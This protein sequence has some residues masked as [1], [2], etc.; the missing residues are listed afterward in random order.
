MNTIPDN[1]A[2]RPA[3]PSAALTLQGPVAQPVAPRVRNSSIQSSNQ[4]LESD[5]VKFT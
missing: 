5:A 1:G 4:T 2:N 3:K